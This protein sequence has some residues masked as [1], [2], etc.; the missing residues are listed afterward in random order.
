MVNIQ[1]EGAPAVYVNRGSVVG[2]NIQIKQG[3]TARIDQAQ[4][5]GDLQF[6]ENRGDLSGLRNEVDGNPAR[7]TVLTNDHADNRCPIIGPTPR[8]R[9]NWEMVQAVLATKFTVHEFY[10]S[11]KRPDRTG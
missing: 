1:T 3:R 4:I 11:N 5:G 9:R 6:F 2:D 7:D 8:K 10:E